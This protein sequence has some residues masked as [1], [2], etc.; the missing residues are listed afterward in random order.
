MIIQKYTYWVEKEKQ[1]D[2]LL[3]LNRFKD[4][5]AIVGVNDNLPGITIGHYFTKQEALTKAK[6]VVLS[7]NRKWH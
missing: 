3:N 5:K 1:I 6:K 4:W 2:S 7:M